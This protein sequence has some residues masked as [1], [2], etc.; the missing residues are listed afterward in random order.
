MVSL[1]AEVRWKVPSAVQESAIGVSLWALAAGVLLLA[2]GLSI[3]DVGRLFAYIGLFALLPGYAITPYVLR[4]P[5]T[6]AM[7]FGSAMFLGLAFQLLVTTLLWLVGLMPGLYLLPVLAAALL[8]RPETRKRLSAIVEARPSAW[9]Y[10]AWAAA[11]VLIPL[12]GFLALVNYMGDVVNDHFIEQAIGV[13]S[14]YDGWP[15][16]NLL[17]PGF[18]YSNNY[19]IH[20]WML[21]ATRLLGL[22]VMV[23]A[24]RATPILTVTFACGALLTFCRQSL[25]LPGW[26]IALILTKIFLVVGR[27]FIASQIFMAVIP[28]ATIPVISPLLGFAVFFTLLLVLADRERAGANMAA[29]LAIL[30]ALTFVATGSRGP[31]GPIVVCALGLWWLA[32]SYQMRAPDWRRLAYVGAA[33]AGLLAALVVFFTLGRGASGTSFLTLTWTPVRFMSEPAN[34]SAVMRWFIQRDYSSTAGAY[35]AFAVV[36]L[37]QAGFLVPGFLYKLWLM[38]RERWTAAETMLLGASIAGIAAVFL[39]EAAGGSHFTFIHYANLSMSVLGGMGLVRMFEGMK[40]R[41]KLAHWLVLVP[42]VTLFVLHMRELP[43]GL[44]KIVP[45]STRYVNN[46]GA[47]PQGLATLWTPA[48]LRPYC[49]N[50]RMAEPLLD[51]LGGQRVN[52]IYIDDNAAFGPCEFIWW[53]A[54][55]GQPSLLSDRLSMYLSWPSA[56]RARMQEQHDQMIAARASA[57]N[58]EPNIE[59]LRRLAAT[60]PEHRDSYFMLPAPVYG[61]EEAAADF[62]RVGV[63]SDLVLWKYLPADG[64]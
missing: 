54:V 19:V 48:S 32:S 45:F 21:G 37:F 61:V 47:G 1:A 27:P 59:A 33:I 63:N 43:P 35:T 34:Y 3:G 52:L 53:T 23:L 29:T 5:F 51:Q 13:A 40:V 64:R 15:P 4:G 62:E 49:E 8:A 31:C 38:F 28:E 17:V 14:L 46:G 39:T 6:P 7:M 57:S 26:A 16:E 41:P 20:L 55:S 24:A 50:Y 2:A 25:R 44:H 60:L 42:T 11:A 9:T 12:L 10:P 58:G 18:P 56:F 36:A 30:A 22:D